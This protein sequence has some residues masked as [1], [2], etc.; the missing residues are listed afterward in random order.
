MR[1]LAPEFVLLAILQV[2]APLVD[3]EGW[4]VERRAAPTT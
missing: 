1:E 3:L 4:Q 2:E